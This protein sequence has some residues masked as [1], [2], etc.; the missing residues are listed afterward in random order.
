MQRKG[1]MVVSILSALVLLASRAPS[2]AQEQIVITTAVGPFGVNSNGA[3]QLSSEVFQIPVNTAS[4]LEA[5]YTQLVA[6]TPF[7]CPKESLQ[8]INF[9]H[10]KRHLTHFNMASIVQKGK[11]SACPGH[12]AVLGYC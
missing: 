10:L 11:R 8:N 1:A 12:R 4:V 9:T 3:G 7:L 2:P 5:E 6:C